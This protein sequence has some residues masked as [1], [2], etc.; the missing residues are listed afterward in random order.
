MDAE[1]SDIVNAQP[2]PLTKPQTKKKKSK[3]QTTVQKQTNSV[4]SEGK[5]SEPTAGTP[6]SAQCVVESDSTATSAMN[7]IPNTQYVNCLK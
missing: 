5:G 2:P 3:R 7:G 1:K 6:T 4:L